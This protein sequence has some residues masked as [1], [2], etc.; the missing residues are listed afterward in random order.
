MHSLSCVPTLCFQSKGKSKKA[1]EDATDDDSDD[2]S[3]LASLKKPRIKISLKEGGEGKKKGKKASKSKK[4]KVDGD[5]GNEGDDEETPAH[6][7]KRKRSTDPS[8]KISRKRTKKADGTASKPKESPDSV[9]GGVNGNAD[10][11][12][13][14]DIFLDTEAWKAKRTDLDGS[15]QSARANLLSEGPWKIP[16]AVGDRFRSVARQTLTKMGRYVVVEEEYH[17]LCFSSHV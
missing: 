7:K 11:A 6:G 5:E 2:D 12:D 13:S 1:A 16:K 8:K 9:N 15:F 14:A 10:T 3:A 4:G 17:R